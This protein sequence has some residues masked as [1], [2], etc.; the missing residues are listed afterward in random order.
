MH[1][2]IGKG[3]ARWWLLAALVVLVAMLVG[4][5]G[6]AASEPARPVRVPAMILNLDGVI[7]PASADYFSRALQK[8]A[9]EHAPLVIVRMDTPGGLDVSMRAMIRDILASPVPVVTYISPSGARG[10]SAGTFILYASHF[11]AMAP[12]TNIGAATPV[13]IGGPTSPPPTPSPS[14]EQPG[15]DNKATPQKAGS[16]MEAKAVNDA[17]AYIRSLAELRRRNADWAEKAVRE[18]A[19]LSASAALRKRVIDI[20]AANV[21]DLLNQLDGR[22]ATAAGT[23]ITLDTRGLGTLEV[24]PDWRTQL[25]VAITNPNVALILMM[26]GIY[27][28]IFEFMNPGFVAP[29]T[30]GAICLLTALYAFAALPV[31]YAGLALIALG[32]GLMIAEAFMASFGTLGV[33]GVVALVLGATMLI[34]TDIPDFR[35][36][37]PVIGGIAATSLI[38]ILAIARLA[39][40]SHRRAIGSGREEMVGLPGTVDDWKG[41]QGHVFAHGERWQATGPLTLTK[42]QNIRVTALDGLT[43]RVDAEP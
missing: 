21:T 41:G 16:T 26:V 4:S 28:L 9:Q 20:V 2:E 14:D 12:G 29:G 34:D 33:G 7:G 27:G 39:L 18:A 37:W 36:A 15:K 22:T 19:S 42:G 25:L 35:I 1:V 31:N 10:A 13:Q 23:R 32:V 38:F 5:G 43:L 40:M 30:I 24:K 6:M 8:A 3:H 17:V 11:A